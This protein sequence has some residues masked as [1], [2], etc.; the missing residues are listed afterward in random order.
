YKTF[1]ILEFNLNFWYNL[2]VV[3]KK[4][5]IMD[6][7]IQKAI[8]VVAKLRAPEGC[9]W[10]RQQTHESIRN[11]LLEE[12]YELIDA[13]NQKDDYKIK[14]ELG[15]VF[16]QVLMHAQIASEENKF[17]L[18]DVAEQLSSKL[19]RRHPHVFGDVNVE[20]T[21]QVIDNWEKIKVTEKGYTDRKSAVDGIPESFTALMKAYKIGKKAVKVGFDWDSIDGALDKLDEEIKELKEAIKNN[22]EE[23]HL[24]EELGDVL[25]C[26]CNV[27][28]KLKIQP[29]VALNHTVD[30]FYNRF[31]L[32]EKMINEDGKNMKEMPLSEMDKYWDRAKIILKTENE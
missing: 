2:M 19:I 25:F 29:E 28:R 27:S 18:G 21:D 11:E 14:D 26:I 5:H 8:D 6:E 17:D 10:D 7:K 32:M 1:L 4:E 9:P 12:A 24:E 13:I 3:K 16:M 22:D 23:K 31:T 20:N 15:D 30:K